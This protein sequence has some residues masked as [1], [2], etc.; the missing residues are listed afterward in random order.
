MCAPPAGAPAVPDD[1][2]PDVAGDIDRDD[3]P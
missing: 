1:L 2:P 3:E